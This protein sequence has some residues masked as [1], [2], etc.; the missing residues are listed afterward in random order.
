MQ[1]PF[2]DLKPQYHSLKKEI[3]VA[4]LSVIE[5]TTFV[6]GDPLTSFE[7]N[8]AAA[9]GAK[10]SIGV[11]NGTDAL[12][13]ILRSLGITAGDEVI[14]V[15]NSWIST[16][17]TISQSG[18]KPIFVDIEPD[19]YTI[20]VSKIEE[21]ITDKTKAIIP[22]HLYGQMAEIDKIDALCKKHNLF[23][24]EDCAQAHLAENKAIKAGTT[25]IAAAFSFY[26]GKNLGAYGDGG[27]I[28]TNDDDLAIK[29]RMFANHGALIKH[30]HQIEGINSRLDTIQAAIL[31]VKLPHLQ[32]WNELRLRNALLYNQVLADVTEIT[33]PK[34]HSEAKHTFHLYVI[35]AQRRNELMNYLTEKGIQ[36]QIHYPTILPLLPAYNYLNHKTEDFPVAAAYQDSILSLPM[37][38]ELTEEQINFV[39]ETIKAFYK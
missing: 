32:K 26:P 27:A 13:I 9:C 4:V 38:P 10:Y 18:A 34:I 37:F 24:I 7:N 23:L 3:D 17:E 5:N 15:A 19:Y 35:R 39:A 8:F 21:K 14:T 36:T 1:V 2:V 30:Q 16:S 25:G 22:V 28:I 20:D 6:G 33:T 29:M 12:Y 31:N 11:G